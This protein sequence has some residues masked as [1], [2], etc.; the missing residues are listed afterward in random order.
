MSKYTNKLIIYFIIFTTII[1]SI[2]CIYNIVKK[3]SYRNLDSFLQDFFIYTFENCSYCPRRECAITGIC[4]NTSSEFYS[5]YN[6]YLCGEKENSSNCNKIKD[7]L[8]TQKS[9]QIIENFRNYRLL[10]FRKGKH[11]IIQPKRGKYYLLNTYNPLTWRNIK[12]INKNQCK[13]FYEKNPVIFS[14]VYNIFSNNKLVKSE[15]PLESQFEESSVYFKILFWYFRKSNVDTILSKS[16]KNNNI[17]SL[18]VGSTNITSDYDMTLYGNSYLNISKTITEFKTEFYKIFNDTSDSVFDTNLYGISF[19]DIEQ[20]NTTT[21]L[22]HSMYSHLFSADIKNCGNKRF[23]YVK[24]DRLTF[25]S[26]HIWALVKVLVKLEEIQKSDEIIYEVMNKNLESICGENIIVC[27]LINEAQKT[28]NMYP[29]NPENLAEIINL[30]AKKNI[31]TINENYFNNFISYVSYNSLESY[32]CRGTF[33]DVVVNSQMCGG[34][35]SKIQLTA[36]EYLDSFIENTAEL[37]THYHKDKYVKRAKSALNNL[38]I[39]NQYNINPSIYSKVMEK[40]EQVEKMQ[41]FCNS[42]ETIFICAPFNLM[43]EC[44]SCIIMIMKECFY[45]IDP[46][47]ILEGID[48]FIINDVDYKRSKLNIKRN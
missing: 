35:S 17:M 15:V 7:N 12:G 3:E 37:L 16:L 46:D 2:F 19:I 30:L 11:N 8:E 41:K 1:I 5:K 10:T 43:V 36:D 13:L 34:D 23:K 48:N 31:S 27:K 14:R 22:N 9:A 33:L 21:E 6:S 39:N 32:F 18:S 29:S 44:L 45:K 38:N 24:S 4:N 42:E 26:S 28:I 20:E 25:I 40:L 47:L